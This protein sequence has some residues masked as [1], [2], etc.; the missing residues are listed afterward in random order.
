[1]SRNFELLKRAE[2]E[3]RQ[4][5]VERVI[6]GSGDDGDAKNAKSPPPSDSILAC[7][8]PS[9]SL[10]EMARGEV[11]KFVQRLFLLQGSKAP[12]IV[13]LS[14]LEPTNESSWVASCASEVLAAL[15]DGSVCLVDAN[16]RHP[17]VHEHFG[18]ANHH[19]FTD[20]IL[21]SGSLWRFTNQVSRNLWLLTCGGLLTDI[22]ELFTAQRLRSRFQ[23]LRA[24]FEYV[25]I[26][27]A[28]PS[29]HNDAAMLGQLADGM[30]L[31]VEAH[32]TRRDEAQ[33]VTKDLAQANVRMLGV[34]LNNSTFPI[35]QAIY[36]RL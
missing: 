26:E 28:A 5:K 16:L 4:S 33:R 24:E 8:K 3:S 7:K 22:N 15:V 36:S 18:I 27:T 6:F 13:V 32:T 30:V 14:G 21:G 20:A 17:I 19:G 34:V 35:P 9:A 31:V 10:T 29:L 11:I 1:M 12:R 23:E 25:L 2:E